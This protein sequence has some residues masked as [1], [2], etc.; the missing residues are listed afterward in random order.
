MDGSTVLRRKWFWPWQD[1]AEEAW[2]ER[3][4][5]EEGLHLESVRFF[6]TYAFSRSGRLPYAY[7]LDYR[8]TSRKERETYRQ[9]FRDA[10]W[11]HVGEMNG[12]QYFRKPVTPGE[13]SEILT[14]R[15]SK[16]EKYR[17]LSAS[18]AFFCLFS[19]MFLARTIT[20]G[21]GSPGNEPLIITWAALVL[22]FSVI[23]FKIRSR[24]RRLRSGIRR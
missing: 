18:Y 11:E 21:R 17:R 13:S 15:E 10:G 12:W 9:L 7:R 16:I 3:L 1:E 24:I 19:M 22:A 23:T 8:R 14:D 20:I 6:N 5:S 2:L 4:S